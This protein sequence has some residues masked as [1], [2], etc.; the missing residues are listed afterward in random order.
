MNH[1]DLETDGIGSGPQQACDHETGRSRYVFAIDVLDK[2]SKD[3]KRWTRVGSRG[4]ASS[5]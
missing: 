4:G 2:A 1:G 3:L 5:F